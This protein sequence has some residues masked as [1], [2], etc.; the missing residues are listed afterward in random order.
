MANQYGIEYLGDIPLAKSIRE[1]ADTG[2][3]IVVSDPEGELAN[4]YRTI[5]RNVSGR[6]AARKRDYS[7]VIP[8]IVVQ[9]N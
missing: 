6:L 4:T 7:D 8:S 9:N 1:G 2:N 3:P 5:A